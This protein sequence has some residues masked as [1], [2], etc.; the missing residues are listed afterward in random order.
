M[1][2]ATLTIVSP[3]SRKLSRH[4]HPFASNICIIPLQLAMRFTALLSMKTAFFTQSTYLRKIGMG[5]IR[6][7]KALWIW[8]MQ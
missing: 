2:E 3:V 7:S 5:W 1:E 4:F 8:S 6:W